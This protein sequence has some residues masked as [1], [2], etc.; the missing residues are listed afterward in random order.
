MKE[1]EEGLNE[2]TPPYRKGKIRYNTQGF[3][4]IKQHLF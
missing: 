3:K 4:F 1:S 2:K